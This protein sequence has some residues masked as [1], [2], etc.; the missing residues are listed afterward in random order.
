[1]P[2]PIGFECHFSVDLFLLLL[3][4]VA[5]T[6]IGLRL[7][8]KH[9]VLLLICGFGGAGLLGFAVFW[10]YVAGPGLGR[11]CGIAVTAACLVPLA[12]GCRERFGAW[13][14]LRPFAP[15]G[16]LFAANGLFNLA[17][18]YLHGGFSTQANVAIDRYG[19]GLPPDGV[20]PMLFARQ[21]QSSTRP[22]PSYLI[23]GWQSSDRPPLQT[24][25]FLL[26]QSVLGSGHLD[27]YQILGTLLQATWVVGLWALLHAAGK[28]RRAVPLCLAAVL[29]SG[30][31]IQNSFF[32]WPKLLAATGILLA[33]AVLLT[34]QLRGLRTSRAAGALVG[35]SLGIAMLGHP[36]TL[37]ALVGIVGGI[38]VLWLVRR[39]RPTGWQPPSWR[40]IAAS[41]AGFAVA[42]VPWSAYQ[43]FVDP[44]GNMLTEVNM[45]GVSGPVPGSTLKVILHAYRKAGLRQV[46]AN[47]ESNYELPFRHTLGY[48][49]EVV[50]LPYHL[51][52]GQQA[53]A[54]TSAHNIVT[55]QFFFLGPILGFSGWGLL[56]FVG[57]VV[58]R[59]VGRHPLPGFQPELLWLLCLVI[60]LLVWPLV[61]FGGN[62][63]VAHQG[64]YFVEPVLIAVGVLGFWSLS[65]KAAAV[66]TAASCAMTLWV[67]IGFTPEAPVPGSGNTAPVSVG[68]AALL[69]FSIAACLACLWWVGVEQP[70]G[71]GDTTD[72]PAALS[73]PAPGLS[74]SVP[75][76]GAPA[77]SEGGRHAVL[78][79]DG[80]RDAAPAPLHRD[81]GQQ[82]HD[83]EQEEQRTCRQAQQLGLPAAV[84]VGDH[85][86]AEN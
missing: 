63:T 28:P 11:A 24:G 57:R 66:V 10:A 44:P 39:L 4:M 45:A 1:V 27:D 36:G 51:I 71:F 82:F 68:T 6:L 35:L 48:L 49:R 25:Y 5:C 55:W 37:F 17:L 58:R 73:R 65:P 21:V 31:V 67:F 56:V 43:R 76:Q 9:P 38:A 2:D 79:G 30:F 85:E 72:E 18:G 60:T 59:A 62:A 61:M 7:G 42:C 46:I 3:P 20:L 29:F 8:V 80:S 32:T 41:A 34:P 70:S 81:R 12:D 84:R 52:A 33:A 64:T 22:I 86:A 14:R 77:G 53:A 47:K 13:R 23:P 50:A 54:Q 75:P 26:Q 74:R 19:I 40:F 83:A 16:A 15:V 78:L 69:A